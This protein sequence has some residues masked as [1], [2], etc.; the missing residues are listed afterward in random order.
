MAANRQK[1]IRT[2]TTWVNGDCTYSSLVKPL[3]EMERITV[4]SMR[5]RAWLSM[6]G[7]AWHTAKS[8]TN[9]QEAKQ[10]NDLYVWKTIGWTLTAITLGV[11]M[12]TAAKETGAGKIPLGQ[13]SFQQRNF[14]HRR[15]LKTSFQTPGFFTQTWTR[16]AFTTSAVGFAIYKC[17]GIAFPLLMNTLFRKEH[18]NMQPRICPVLLGEMG[19]V[20]LPFFMNWRKNQ[21][22]II[23]RK[24][25]S[26]RKQTDGTSDGNRPIIK[27]KNVA[28]RIRE[29]GRV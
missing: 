15:S 7:G 26:R 11:L 8:N 27:A 4:H 10:A 3:Q 22:I 16:N 23:D 21:W 12:N 28:E 18:N 20:R 24:H 17:S 14:D 2:S 9:Q 25:P 13:Y 19:S 29:R 1:K 6:V 5:A